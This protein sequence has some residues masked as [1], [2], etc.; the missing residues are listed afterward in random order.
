MRV[1]FA[2]KIEKGAVVM[3]TQV[4]AVTQALFIL[5]LESFQ[6]VFTSRAR[7]QLQLLV[8]AYSMCHHVERFNENYEHLDRGRSAPTAHE[9]AAIFLSVSSNTSHTLHAP[10]WSRQRYAISSQSQL[11]LTS[12]D[13]T[14]IHV[15][16]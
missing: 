13:G 12:D 6:A 9:S 11:Q 7:C 3:T 4:L 5:Q 16:A 15:S 2:K 8:S 1:S 14:R 10:A